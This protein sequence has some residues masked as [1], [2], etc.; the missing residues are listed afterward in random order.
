MAAAAEA[1]LMVAE[2]RG[3][4]M[5]AHVGM[6]L[7]LHGTNSRV[8]S[9]KGEALGPTKAEARR[10]KQ[11]GVIWTAAASPVLCR[12]SRREVDCN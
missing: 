8:Q 12:A 10:I 4:L 7:A 3:P 11:A 6:M 2:D 9:L 1:L 5:H